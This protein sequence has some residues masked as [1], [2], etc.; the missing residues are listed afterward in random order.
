MKLDRY[1]KNEDCIIVGS[2]IRVTEFFNQC[3][4]NVAKTV[5]RQQQ[6]DAEQV[7]TEQVEQQADNISGDE[8]P[9]STSTAAL[10]TSTST[11]KIEQSACQVTV[12]GN[13]VTITRD[14][15]SYQVR[16]LAKNMSSLTLKVNITAARLDLLH[17]DTV[18][19]LKAQ[20]RMAFI[21][22]AA[23]ELLIDPDIIKKD[24]GYLLLHLEDLRNEQIAAAKC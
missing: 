3:A 5:A 12:T 22:A 18:D 20:S 10:S 9:S 15:R 13:Q 24:L 21:K 2:G 8:V 19:L 6:Q 14:D 1:C 4:Q 16:G 11:T 7:D 17:L 23:T